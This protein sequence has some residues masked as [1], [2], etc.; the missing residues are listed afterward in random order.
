MSIST[1]LCVFLSQVLL[2]SAL[3]RMKLRLLR[4]SPSS[5]GSPL[6]TAPAP[7][8]AHTASATGA[9]AGAVAVGRAV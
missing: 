9:G 8:P 7:A 1:I 3:N 4:P 5:L 6:I 2:A